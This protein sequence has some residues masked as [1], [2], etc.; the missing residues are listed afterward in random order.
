MSD[1]LYSNLRRRAAAWAG[2]LTKLAK[3][4]APAHIRP[5][6]SSHT[7]DKGD[8]TYIIRL[9]ADRRLPLQPRETSPND[10]RAQEFGSG[11]HSRRG[12]KQ[13]YPIFPVNGTYLAFNENAN[14]TWDYSLTT[15]P[16]PHSHLPDGRGIFTHVMH[17]GIE[18]ANGGEG[19]MA[20]AISDLKA[21]AREELDEDIRKA[22]LGDLR[23]GFRRKTA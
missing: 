7:E 17:P 2:Q 18:A 23:E 19:F 1:R 16:M 12:S 8:G 4:Y 9:T 20:P 15:P 5:A 13:K 21:R 14:G 3:G 10:V 11:E 6:I 22:I